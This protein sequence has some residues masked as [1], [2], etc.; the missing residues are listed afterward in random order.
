MAKHVNTSLT[1]LQNYIPNERLKVP[2]R[3]FHVYEHNFVEEGAKT[4][5]LDANG[6][7]PQL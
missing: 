4:L 5:N 3:R 7:T 6:T 2:V 1:L